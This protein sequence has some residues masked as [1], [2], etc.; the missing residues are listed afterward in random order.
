MEADF[1][2]GNSNDVIT[3]QTVTEMYDFIYYSRN[4]ELSENSIWEVA[5]RNFSRF[6]AAI[7]TNDFAATSAF[8]VNIFQNNLTDGLGGGASTYELA[9]RYPKSYM[10]LMADKLI[11]LQ[12]QIGIRGPRSVEQ[13][14]NYLEQ[15]NIKVDDEV[16]RLCC[17]LGLLPSLRP[18]LGGI[19]GF[20]VDSQVWAIRDF[21]HIALALHLK[22]FFGS[23]EDLSIIEI[24]GGYGGLA[25][26]LMRLGAKNVIVYDLPFVTLL[27][28]FFL[29]HCSV[30]YSVTL[31]N[32]KRYD[33]DEPS[34]HL[35]SCDN[36]SD[37]TSSKSNIFVNQDSFS[38]MDHET[39]ENYLN[40]IS[41]SGAYL[42]S[43]NQ[44]SMAKKFDG[45]QLDTSEIILSTGKFVRILRCPFY[46][47]SGYTLEI[48][49][50]I[51]R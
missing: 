45:N 33:T 26:W 7:E 2:V 18:N 21:E 8:L 19:F 38:E 23:L 5:S 47:R 6:L 10:S 51:E 48:Y 24:G 16:K 29:K 22:E 40:I 14:I 12:E 43:V 15:I 27:Q 13:R 46:L 35:N 30:N 20:A 9:K 4:N 36:V 1:A 39:V 49:K 17:T 11:R 28:Y 41:S 34:I 37:V 50:T 44:Q 25:Y 31:G 42:V 3:M 32:Q